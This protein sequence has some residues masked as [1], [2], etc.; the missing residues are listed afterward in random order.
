MRKPLCWEIS[1]FQQVQ[2]C[3]KLRE[4]IVLQIRK[5]AWNFLGY[6]LALDESSYHSSTSQLLSRVRHNLSCSFVVLLWT[7]ISQKIWHLFAACTEQHPEKTCSW[8][9]RKLYN[10]ITFRRLS[11]D[12]LQLMGGKSWLVRKALLAQIKIKLEDLYSRALCLY[13]ALYISKNSVG[14]T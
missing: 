10:V 7:F 4:N 8:K 5:K 1:T 2:L 12:V 11:V 9:Y 6:P 14:N 3:R 13:T